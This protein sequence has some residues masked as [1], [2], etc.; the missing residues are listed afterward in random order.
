MALAG[1]PNTGKTTLFNQLTGHR[2]RVGNYPGV[3]VERRSGN[4]DLDGPV[5]LLDTPGTYSLLARSED[6]QVAIAA[7]LGMD[8]HPRPD[9]IIV[10]VDAT[11]LVRNLYLA[12]QLI[13]FGSPCVIALNM[14]DE[15]PIPP[16][17]AA[18]TA[19]LG[20]P[21]VPTTAREGVGMD[22]L[23]GALSATLAHRSAPPRPGVPYPETVTSALDGILAELP[24]G[25]A[26][27]GMGLWCLMS[28]AP[29]GSERLKQLVA[30]ARA[31]TDIDQD[32][33]A[34]RYAFL[35]T[36]DSAPPEATLTERVDRVLL[37]PIAGF[38]VF[39]GVMLTLFQVLFTGADPAIG[40]LEDVLGWLQGAATASLP[41]GVLTE[42]LTEGMIGGVGNALVF[43]PQILLLFFLLGLLE[44]SGYM[45]RVAYLMDRVMR[46]LG[47][48]GRAFVPML[49]GLACA[50]P[51]IMAT[52]T[53]ER[54]RDRLMVM[55][56]VPLMTCSARL[57]VYTL[58]IASLFPPSSLFG[59]VPVQGLMMMAMYLFGLLTTLAVAGVLGKTALRGQ[60][61]GLILELPPYRMPT[62]M[63]LL[64]TMWERGKIFLTEAGTVIAVCTVIMWALLRFPALPEPPGGVVS[65]SP[66]EVTAWQADRLEHSAAGRLGRGMEPVLA[67][68]GF[69]WKMGVGIVGAF[70]AREVFVST[71]GIVYGV[72]ED[73]TEETP[74]LR[75]RMRAETRTDGTPV[76]TPLVGV[77][78]MVFFSLAC[79]CMS[80][81]AIIKRETRSWKWPAFVFVYM[82]VLAWLASFAIYQIG[83]LLGIGT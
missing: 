9:A 61:V 13:E 34:A 16:D 42:L 21:C 5:E 15:A 2:A 36:L 35:E 72:G 54:R 73:V 49:S 17:P 56:V 75:D 46:A 76:Y 69:D 3:T 83:S 14:I 48:H 74:A 79:Q 23:R 51:A 40:L 78:L 6:E 41:A 57:P 80:T 70:A 44:D 31:H 33:I 45:A 38:A 20:V 1:N 52:R 67:P 62:A 28:E 19:L 22:A 30:S 68:L 8:G 12:L 4:L 47:L 77:S 82:S 63:A 24:D 39:A 59:I 64:R 26:D 43:L 29:G 81:L 71:M 65:L 53:L 32:I 18:I 60:R 37:H 25:S 58:I 7:L 27:P 66:A 11:Q 10:V 55:A 50:V